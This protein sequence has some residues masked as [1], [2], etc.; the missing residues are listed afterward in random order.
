MPLLTHILG[1]VHVLLALVSVYGMTQA[2]SPASFV[3]ALLGA[4]LFFGMAV[5]IWARSRW[6]L[7]PG[8]AL[9]IVFGGAAFLFSLAVLWPE[10]QV[11]KLLLA[12]SLIVVLEILSVV[13]TMRA[14]RRRVALP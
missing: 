8:I 13:T 11:R 3:V 10:D 5:T 7:M 2:N 12:C 14:A 4:V 6:V 9:V 1:A